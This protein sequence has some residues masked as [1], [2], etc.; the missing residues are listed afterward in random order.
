VRSSRLA[1]TWPRP[2]TPQRQNPCRSIGRHAR[3]PRRPRS[4]A[5]NAAVF[6]HLAQWT[7]SRKKPANVLIT[8]RCRREKRY[9]SPVGILHFRRRSAASGSDL[10]ETERPED[11]E[12]RG[13]LRYPPHAL[14][15][16]RDWPVMSAYR[17]LRNI[18][19]GVF[20]LRPWEIS[21][22]ITALGASVIDCCQNRINLW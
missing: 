3:V 17:K 14:S 1:R 18:G 12:K 9:S 4:V 15:T 10:S 2:S 7:C 6:T 11:P 21:H 19:H 13:Q 8:P 20:A 5:G 22:P 16:G